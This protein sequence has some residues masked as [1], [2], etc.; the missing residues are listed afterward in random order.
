M[1]T[2]DF[3]P[4]NAR[5]RAL[6]LACALLPLVSTATVIAPIKDPTPPAWDLRIA[7]KLIAVINWWTRSF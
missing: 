1:L 5:S 7:N 3:K 6:A 2:E 4:A